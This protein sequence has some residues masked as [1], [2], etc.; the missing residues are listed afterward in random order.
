MSVPRRGQNRSVRLEGIHA[1]QLQR[2]RARV[3]VFRDGR[4]GNIRLDPLRVSVGEVRERAVAEPV[5]PHEQALERVSVRV[6]NLGGGGDQSDAQ[7]SLALAERNHAVQAGHVE[8]VHVDHGRVVHREHVDERRRRRGRDALDVGDDEFHAAR[9]RVGFLSDVRV[10]HVP[11]RVAQRVRRGSVVRVQRAFASHERCVE[12]QNAVL[13]V[14][15][16]V[17][18][19]APR[20]RIGRRFCDGDDVDAGTDSSPF[21]RNVRLRVFVSRHLL[22]VRVR[23]EPRSVRVRDVQPLQRRVHGVC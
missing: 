12:H 15:R 3:P 11:Q 22:V 23:L 9:R 20:D 21:V 2:E 4:S 19:T 13:F 16:D 7:A 10:G 8:P 17:H 1:H 6:G 5:V 18:A 14:K